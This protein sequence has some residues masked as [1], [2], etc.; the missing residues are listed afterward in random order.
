[1][2]PIYKKELKSYFVSFTGP[3]VIAF[4][5]L[6]S[7]IFVSIYCFFSYTSSIETTYSSTVF[8]L[9]VAVPLLTM[10]S[11]SEERH[12]KTDLLIGS[13]PIRPV[14]FVLGKYFAMMTIVSIPLLVT[15]LYTL[16]LSAYGKINFLSAFFAT[17][18]FILCAGALISVGLFISSL[19]DNAALSAT[20]T[21]AAILAVCFLPDIVLMIPGSAIGSFGV[22]SAFALLISFAAAYLFSNKVAGYAFFLVCEGI[23]LALLCFFPDALKGL[24]PSLMSSLSVTDRFASFSSY[25]I[26]DV[27]TIVYYLSVSLFFIFLTMNSLERRYRG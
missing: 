12:S 16:I 14:S 4:M 9:I 5:L 22:F 20:V 26:F 21:F 7:G 19:F 1:M 6:F 15:F 13:L 10:R 17:A 25:G 2:L 27:S 3:A 8:V 18:A 23:L 11:I 24:A